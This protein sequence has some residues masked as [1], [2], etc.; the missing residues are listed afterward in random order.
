[1]RTA[2]LIAEIEM[3]FARTC[4][5]LA[6]IIGSGSLSG[7]ATL[8]QPT[9]SEIDSADRVFQMGKFV[10]A[11]KIYSQIVTQNPKDYSATLQLGRIAL[12]SNQLDDAQKWLEKAI[13]LKPGD[14]DAK[15]MLAEAF[16]RRDDFQKAAAS[17][18]GVEV[19][20]NQL[21]ISQY[22]SLNVAKLESF[23]GQTPYQLHGNGTSTRLK[24]VK[25]EPLPVVSV[26]VNGS[27]EVAFFIDTGGSEVALDTDFAKELG[28]PQFGTVQGTFSGGQHAE[29]QQGRIESLTVGDWTVKN[30]PTAMLPLRQLSKGFGVKQIDGIIGTTLFYHFLTTMDYPRGE[31]LLRRKTVESLE[32]FKKS[33]GKKVAI[34]IWMASDHFMVGW[35]RVETLP[36]TLLF[37]DTGLMGAGVKL[38]ESVIKEAGIKLEENKASEGA[39]GGGKLKIVPYTVHHLSFG[40]I[41]EEN[42]PGLYDGPFPWENMFGFHLAGM[43]GHDFFKPYAMTFDFQNMQIFLQ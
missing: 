2:T 32:Q 19:S 3:K 22:P 23:K 34:P 41:K 42:V 24:F 14:A 5:A 15:V 27:D 9:Q 26:R 39:G 38:A 30:L 40:E 37:V 6:A 43:V 8:Q 11:G 28:V 36:P 7:Q 35:G 12:L 1:L 10:E 4:I 20:S 21:L 13:A 33:P 18:N 17:L 25:T 16:Y 29:V 31:L